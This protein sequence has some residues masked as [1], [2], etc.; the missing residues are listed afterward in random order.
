MIKNL[1][2]VVV[3]VLVIGLLSLLGVIIIG[4]FYVALA[5]SRPVDDSVINL[6]KMSI[7]GI[8]GIVAGYVARSD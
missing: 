4:D 8:I 2:D 7:T 6:L 5:E 3:I 1:K